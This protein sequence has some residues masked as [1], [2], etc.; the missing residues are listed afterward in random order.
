MRWTAGAVILIISLFI[1]GTAIAGQLEDAKQAYDRGDYKTAYRLYKSLAERGSPIAQSNLG[2]LYYSSRG[3]S[4]D[5]AEAMKWFRKAANQGDAVGQYYIGLM[6]YNG[7]TVRQNYAE[8]MKWFRKAANQGDADAQYS[9]GL[10]YGTGKGVPQD[11]VLAY[12]WLN[13]ASSRF[14]ASEK[15]RREKAEKNRDIA[16]SKMTPAQ[17]AEAQKLAREWKP[18]KEK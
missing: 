4:Q 16:A 2:L 8:A 10:M 7:K 14:S 6:Y 18:K 1:V 3:V 12:M 5:Y 13:L 9:L 17:I 11:D 15:E